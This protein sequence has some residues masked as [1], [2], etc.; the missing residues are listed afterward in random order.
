MTIDEAL[1]KEFGTQAFHVKE[2]NVTL[3][4]YWSPF[5]MATSTDPEVRD[6]ACRSSAL[7]STVLYIRVQYLQ[8]MASKYDSVL[9]SDLPLSLEPIPHGH[10]Q[11]PQRKDCHM[12]R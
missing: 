12:L 7:Y 4:S 8:Q 2:Y 11:R 10:L 6:A 3:F 5:L 9:T 1:T